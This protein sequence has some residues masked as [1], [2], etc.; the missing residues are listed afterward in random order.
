VPTNRFYFSSTDREEH[1]GKLKFGADWESRQT[2]AEVERLRRF[3]DPGPRWV[4]I[5]DN[6]PYA[7]SA[8]EEWVYPGGSGDGP[9][10]LAARARAL[11]RMRQL[12]WVQDT[13]W[14]FD[15]YPKS[16]VSEDFER[17]DPGDDREKLREVRRLIAGESQ[18][19]KAEPEAPA[20]LVSEVKTPTATGVSSQRSIDTK[21]RQFEAYCKEWLVDWA[22]ENPDRPPGGHKD[23]AYAMAQKKFAGLERRTFNRAWD[24]VVN[25]PTPYPVMW[26]KPGRPPGSKKSPQGNRRT[27]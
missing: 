7:S 8:L 3:Y 18:G 13:L 14:L 6:G 9:Q 27:D 5:G 16:K 4:A 20:A 25:V 19:A 22:A 23:A 21:R 10:A 1:L 11:K 26:G 12:A 24:V 15:K 17:L 2:D